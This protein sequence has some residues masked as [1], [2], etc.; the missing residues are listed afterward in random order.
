MAKPY[1]GECYQF[2]FFDAAQHADPAVLLFV[3]GGD[4]VVRVNDTFSGWLSGAVGDEIRS[5]RMSPV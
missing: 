4:G 5:G 3:E 1:P 2:L